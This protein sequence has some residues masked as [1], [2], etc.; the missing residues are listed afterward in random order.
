ME[1]KRKILFTEQH[2]DDAT[3]L[4]ETVAKAM[5]KLNARAAVYP[6]MG[7]WALATPGGVTALNDKVIQR[8]TLRYYDTKEAAEMVA[9]HNG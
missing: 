7:R 9:I 8:G 1:F 3:A 6:W 5:S 4:P 2:V